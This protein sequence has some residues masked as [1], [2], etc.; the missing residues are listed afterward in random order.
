MSDMLLV[1][2]IGVGFNGTFTC[3]VDLTLVDPDLLTF[4][5]MIILLDFYFILIL[6]YWM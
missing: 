3:F 6:N 1:S 5:L 4:L 2:L